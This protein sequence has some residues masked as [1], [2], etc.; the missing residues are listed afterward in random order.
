M[1]RVEEREL[2]NRKASFVAGVVVL[3]VSIN[4]I[5]ELS[6][7]IPN[8]YY[9]V[10]AIM[11][12]I[13]F[14][15]ALATKKADKILDS[16]G[17]AKFGAFLTVLSVV[18][19]S[20]AIC[21]KRLSKSSKISLG[22]INEKTFASVLMSI[23][24]SAIIGGALYLLLQGRIKSKNKGNN[25]KYR[26]NKLASHNTKYFIAIIIS[27]VLI[28]IGMKLRNCICSE[29]LWGIGCS[30]FTAAL[31]ALFIETG[32]EIK[33]SEHRDKVRNL[34]LAAIYHET[35]TLAERIIWFDKAFGDIDFTNE[36][37]YYFTWGAFVE[38]AKNTYYKYYEIV[39]IEAVGSR[40]DQLE[41]KY[42]LEN[43][44]NMSCTKKADIEKMFRVIGKA[45]E[46]F[47]AAINTLLQNKIQYVADGIFEEDEIEQITG[48]MKN[49]VEILKTP[50]GNYGCAISFLQEEYWNLLPYMDEKIPLYI[51][52]KGKCSML[53]LYF[54]NRRKSIRDKS[55]NISDENRNDKSSLD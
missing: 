37:D 23:I 34:C 20:T 25:K 53:D 45:S 48:G 6:T 18:E 43:L 39:D 10:E 54:S 46:S 35:R 32:D 28:I 38:S 49:I 50:S 51:T 15:F 19:F 9:F 24:V 13:L 8:V 26:K 22:F 29:L 42:S 55:N 1:D 2:F 44:S 31:L 36:D 3:I 52:W 14:Y 33:K 5:I 17:V 11:V 4:D 40:L 30:G 7:S 21:F 12:W 41:E 47:T 16:D 27:V